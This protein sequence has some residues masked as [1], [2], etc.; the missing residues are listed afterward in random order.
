MY[1][2]ALNLSATSTTVSAL[3]K[4]PLSGSTLFGGVF[5]QHVE[6]SAKIFTSMRETVQSLSKRGEKRPSSTVGAGGPPK[7]DRPGPRQQQQ[8]PQRQQQQANSTKVP[9]TSTKASRRRSA[10]KKKQ[11]GGGSQATPTE[12]KGKLSG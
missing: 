3:K 6:K 4:L 7:K 12:A 8:Q 10:R 5:T 11:S 2:K 1:M 9:G